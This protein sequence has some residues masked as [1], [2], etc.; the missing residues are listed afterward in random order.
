MS[1]VSTSSY[2]TWRESQTSARTQ[3][4]QQLSKRIH[5]IHEKSKGTYGVPRI[6][7]ELADIDELHVGRKRVAR[8]IEQRICGV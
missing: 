1:R 8:L 3:A 6:H 2:Y 7:P 4:N 5:E